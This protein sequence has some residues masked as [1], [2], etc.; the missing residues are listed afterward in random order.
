V[1]SLVPRDALVRSLAAVSRD[2][3]SY[4]NRRLTPNDV[5]LLYAETVRIS[6][7]PL[8]RAAYDGCVAGVISRSR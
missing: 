5:G 8:Q 7:I 1:C 6:P 3:A 2:R 4:L